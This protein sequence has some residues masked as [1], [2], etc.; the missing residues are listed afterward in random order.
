MHR[1][2]NTKIG[3]VTILLACAC[4]SPLK[5]QRE[6]PLLQIDEQCQVFSI[7]TDGRIAYA[8][9]KIKRIKKTQFERDEIWV[10][11]MDGKRTRIVDPDKF[12]PV[13]PPSTYIVDS[14]VWSPDGKRLAVSMTTMA[15]TE[16]LA[17]QSPSGAKVVALFDD[18][19]R[20]IKVNGSKT[21]FIENAAQGTWLADDAT[22]VYLTPGSPSLISR[23]RPAD[24]QS[25]SLFEGHSF[26]AVAWDALRNQAYVIG[27]NLSLRSKNVLAQLDLLK[28]TVREITPVDTYEGQ[29]N[30]S[31]TGTKIG[32]FTNGDSIEVVD[33]GNPAKP[34]RLRTG[35]GRYDWSRDER[36]ILLKRGPDN[37][38]NDMVW[39]G[40]YDGTFAAAL[41]GLEYKNFQITPDGENVAVTEPGSQILKIYPAF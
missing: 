14:L 38:S 31:P 41:R 17:D 2:R 4:A 20:E 30:L 39:V 34:L 12:M 32:F 8:V 24:G 13:P 29:L 15:P 6:K 23:V 1:V 10:A 22:V 19:G 27:Q 5:A 11:R 33:L 16:E 18:E 40:L 25:K 9:P 37:Q 36:R 28:E 7:G 35:I 26:Q 21:R 3:F